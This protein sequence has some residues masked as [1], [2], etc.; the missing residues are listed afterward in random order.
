LLELAGE[1]TDGEIDIAVVIS[2]LVGLVFDAWLALATDRRTG[3]T[4]NTLAAVVMDDAP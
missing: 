3:R 2:K 1:N 4:Y